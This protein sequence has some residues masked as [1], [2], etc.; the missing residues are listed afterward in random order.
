MLVARPWR[1]LAPE[2]MPATAVGRAQDDSG[3]DEEAATPTAKAKKSKKEKVKKDNF[4]D[5]H[6]QVGNPDLEEKV[7]WYNRGIVQVPL[8]FLVT[9]LFGAFYLNLPLNIIMD[10]PHRGMKAGDTVVPSAPCPCNG[11][12][13][14]VKGM[15]TGK[16]LRRMRKARRTTPGAR[17]TQESAECHF[18][19][20]IDWWKDNWIVSR[21]K[22]QDR[23][24]CCRMCLK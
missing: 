18:Y 24:G 11:S 17:P 3:E 22:V 5:K 7:P 6:M 23:D 8:I 2:A 13:A 15:G 9:F 4:S 1:R 16:L 21:A 12:H 19:P 14:S 20:G 10:D